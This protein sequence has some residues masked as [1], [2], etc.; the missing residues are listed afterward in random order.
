[1][2]GDSV[3]FL[4]MV[5]NQGAKPLTGGTP[6]RVS[7]LVNGSEVSWAD[8]TTTQVLPGGMVLLCASGG[9][10]AANS[11]IADTTGSYTVR[12]VIDP[13]N[14]IDEI[15][16]GNN[17]ADAALEVIPRPR[18]N[19]ALRRSV[20]V[21]SIERSGLEGEKAVDGNAGSRWSSAFSD[22]QA[23]TVDLGA[24]YLIDRVI[25]R[26]ETAYGRDYSIQVSDNNALWTMAAYV[27][28]GNGGNDTLAISKAARYVKMFGMKRGTEWGYSLYEFEVYGELVTG[29]EEVEGAGPT[30][31]LLF[32]NYPNPFNPKTVVSSQLPV[33]SQVKLAVY[34]LLG[35]EVAVLLNEKKPAGRHTV[36]WDGRDSQGRQ[37]SSGVYLCRMTAGTFS[38]T[39]RMLLIR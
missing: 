27:Q 38:Q 15:L 13:S 14:T 23:I 11:W 1:V 8:T 26:W 3:L 7:F 24:Q 33:A 6:I 35:R 28:N 37:V 30:E 39:K 29:I 9:P 36:E 34:D 18:A 16:E 22:P 2:K 25:L 17:L 10:S 21:S 4:A 5:K 12:A 20:V 19:L 32:D 31:F